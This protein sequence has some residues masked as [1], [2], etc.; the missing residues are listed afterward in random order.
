MEAA[1]LGLAVALTLPSPGHVP[2][3]DALA[4]VRHLAVP[5]VHAKWAS[6][7][8]P[9]LVAGAS[10]QTCAVT[11]WAHLMPGQRPRLRAG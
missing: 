11:A 2:D 6:R 4:L 9:V 10:T 8:S 5:G 7:F 3:G 1:L